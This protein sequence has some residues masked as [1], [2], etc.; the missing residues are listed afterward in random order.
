MIN[1]HILNKEDLLTKLSVQKNFAKT[2]KR[3]NFPS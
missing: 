1:E 2:L 3:T